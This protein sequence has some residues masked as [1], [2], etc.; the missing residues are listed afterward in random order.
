MTSSDQETGRAIHQKPKT[1]IKRGM[2]MCLRTTVWDIFRKNEEFTDN[3]EDAEVP[4][5][6]HSSLD[7]DSQSLMKVASRKQCL[8]SLPKKK[9]EFARSA[10]ANRDDQ[11]SMQKT[12]W[13]SNRGKI[14]CRNCLEES[15]SIRHVNCWHPSVM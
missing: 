13:R 15:V 5:P 7:S 8:Y 3:L 9:N 4:A 1:K 12:Y 10:K 14:P 6:A 11:G 2:A